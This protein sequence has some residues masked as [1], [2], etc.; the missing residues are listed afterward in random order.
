M[1]R[2]SVLTL[3]T[4]QGRAAGPLAKPTTDFLATSNKYYSLS[5]M[6]PASVHGAAQSVVATAPQAITTRE[7][8]RLD[9]QRSVAVVELPGGALHS[10][11]RPGAPA[12]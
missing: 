12:V 7:E 2:R 11:P 9:S 10:R 4:K 6:K 1:A 5:G 3:L 8:R